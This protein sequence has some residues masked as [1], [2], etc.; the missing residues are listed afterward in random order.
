MLGIQ[1]HDQLDPPPLRA[2]LHRR[3]PDQSATDPAN[4]SQEGKIRRKASIV[5]GNRIGLNKDQQRTIEFGDIH[6]S[7]DVVAFRREPRCLST[8]WGRTHG[9]RRIHPGRESEPRRYF[10]ARLSMSQ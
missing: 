2:A 10:A 3:L 9:P 1:L 7:A 8:A 4:T 6:A 5:P